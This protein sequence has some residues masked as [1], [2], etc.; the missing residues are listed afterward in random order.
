VCE[1]VAKF[2]TIKDCLNVGSP[3]D[4]TKSLLLLSRAA[5]RL[6][7]HAVS[8]ELMAGARTQQSLRRAQFVQRSQRPFFAVLHESVREAAQRCDWYITSADEDI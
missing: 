1:I 7:F 6:G 3:E 4:F 2:L 5:R 8:V